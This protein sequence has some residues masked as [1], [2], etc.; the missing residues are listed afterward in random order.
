MRGKDTMRNIIL[1][2]NN[3]FYGFH[4]FRAQGGRRRD[5]RRGRPSNYFPVTPYERLNKWQIV[6]ITSQKQAVK[7]KLNSIILLHELFIHNGERCVCLCG[8]KILNLC[9]QQ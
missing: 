5:D 8:N 2:D 3:M 4:K 1:L 6:K 7:I 9:A